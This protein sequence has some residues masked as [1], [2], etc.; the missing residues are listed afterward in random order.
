MPVPY[1]AASDALEAYNRRGREKWETC[2]NCCGEG[3]YEIAKPQRDDPYFAV[4]EKCETC[5]GVGLVREK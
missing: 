2:S 5:N 3:A 1:S 4:S